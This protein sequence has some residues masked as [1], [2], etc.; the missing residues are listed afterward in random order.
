MKTAQRNH[1]K[2]VSFVCEDAGKALRDM[3]ETIDALVVDPPR[4][5]LDVLMKEA[6]LKKSTQPDCLCFL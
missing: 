6:I 3:K 4:T 5:G 1:L 2:H